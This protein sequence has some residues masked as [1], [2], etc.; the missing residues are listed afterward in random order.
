MA[1]KDTKFEGLMEMVSLL[2]EKKVLEMELER[3]QSMGD[4]VVDI[5]IT[6]IRTV[7]IPVQ[8][9]SGQLISEVI[10]GTTI[11]LIVK[12]LEVINKILMWANTAI[13][14]MEAE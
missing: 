13:E 3:L 9:H 11:E 10:I 5:T 7:T 2:E 12:R 6:G 1:N 4:S 8:Y 14:N